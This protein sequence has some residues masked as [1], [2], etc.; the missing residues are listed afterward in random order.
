MRLITLFFWDALT[1]AHLLSLDM[2]AQL[3]RPQVKVN[4]ANDDDHR[5][6]GYGA[7][8]V[9]SEDGISHLYSTGADPGVAFIS[10]NFMAH[11][12]DLTVIGNTESDAWPVFG[13]VEELILGGDDE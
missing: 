8:I 2:T 3:L 9:K 7:W 5:H 13:A 12:V 4:L 10:T 11:N 6:Y 1:E